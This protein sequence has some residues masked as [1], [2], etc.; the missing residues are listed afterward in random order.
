MTEL[1]HKIFD[2]SS[3]EIKVGNHMTQVADLGKK[4]IQYVMLSRSANKQDT[5]GLTMNYY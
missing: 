1:I 5:N 4:S 2:E 3:Q